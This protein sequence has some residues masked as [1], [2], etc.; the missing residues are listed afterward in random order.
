M[1]E[2]DEGRRQ[3]A[4]VLVEMVLRD[5]GGIEAAAL[6]MDDLFRA[7]AVALGGRW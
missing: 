7:E 4:L 6:G 5:P 1:A 2:E 3:P